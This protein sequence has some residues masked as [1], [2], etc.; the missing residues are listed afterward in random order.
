MFADLSVA[1]YLPFS[2]V[3]VGIVCGL[4][5][6]VSTRSDKKSALAR[7]FAIVALLLWAQPASAPKEAS[8]DDHAPPKHTRPP[9]HPP[10]HPRPKGEH[11]RVG[12]EQPVRRLRT[13][14]ER[15]R[16]GLSHLEGA[17]A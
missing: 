16:R 3:L 6:T 10:T 15:D 1:L 13:S 7:A 8:R 5:W 12:G 9:A 14:A 11:G 2:L 4:L 17:S